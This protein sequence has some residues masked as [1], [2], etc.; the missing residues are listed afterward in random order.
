MVIFFHRLPVIGIQSQPFVCVQPCRQWQNCRTMESYLCAGQKSRTWIKARSTARGAAPGHGRRELARILSPSRRR[1]WR[2]RSGQGRAGAETRYYSCKSPSRSASSLPH[3]PPS[4]VRRGRRAAVPL[5]GVRWL[6]AC[7]G[8][9]AATTH[10]GDAATAPGRRRRRGSYVAAV[11]V[12]P[13]AFA[14]AGRVD[15]TYASVYSVYGCVPSSR[16]GILRRGKRLEVS[17]GDWRTRET[18]WFSSR[19]LGATAFITFQFLAW[20]L[21]SLVSVGLV[22]SRRGCTVHNFEFLTVDF[23][24]VIATH[25]CCWSTFFFLDYTGPCNNLRPHSMKNEHS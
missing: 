19:W 24:L 9:R 20:S 8:A 11:R 16:R 2:R 14:L 23:S 5:A 4:T 13:Y 3:T 25:S 12:P 22:L 18:W 15:R 1:S 7:E 6:V 21:I 10:T 17:R